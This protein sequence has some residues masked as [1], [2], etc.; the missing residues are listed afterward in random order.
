MPTF[1]DID[2][3]LNTENKDVIISEDNDAIKNSVRNI[4][5]TQKR[6]VPGLPEFGCD[7]E[8]VLYELIDEVTFILIKDTITVE[9]NKWEPRIDVKDITF[10]TDIDNGQIAVLVSYIIIAFNTEETSIITLDTN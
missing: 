3:F 7:L 6:T 1:T 8:S 2:Y 5:T 10:T 9:L 4:I